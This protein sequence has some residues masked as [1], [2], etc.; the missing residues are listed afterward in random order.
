MNKVIMEI[1][2]L[3]LA[4]LAGWW[5]TFSLLR[6]FCSRTTA[7]WLTHGF[8]LLALLA[9]V[10]VFLVLHLSSLTLDGLKSFIPLIFLFNLNIVISFFYFWDKR[11]SQSK[12]EA[13]RI[14]ENVLHFFTFIGGG[15]GAFLSQQAFRHKTQKV[16]FRRIFWL[17]LISSLAIYYG[18][19]LLM[20]SQP[21]LF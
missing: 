11:R 14:P 17:S 3:G 5:L 6:F 12:G 10:A 16:P 1:G 18:V 19:Y 20:Y 21:P 2:L 15:V 9:Q 4:L 8:V 13:E 7:K